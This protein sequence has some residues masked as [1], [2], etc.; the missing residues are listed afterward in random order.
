[1]TRLL[2][3]LILIH[4]VTYCTGLT[5]SVSDPVDLPVGISANHGDLCSIKH[6]VMPL[7]SR[8]IQIENLF[9]ANL[10]VKS[11]TSKT[12]TDH[13]RVNM[14]T[15]SWQQQQNKSSHPSASQNSK[16]GLTLW[17]GANERPHQGIHIQ[18]VLNNSMNMNE[19][20]MCWPLSNH[21]FIWHRVESLFSDKAVEN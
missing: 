21:V 1:M 4:G 11:L 14:Y 7:R 10:N 15:A 2:G 18:T 17:V 16:H 12:F 8:L 20:N 6:N 9:A 5:C 19:S 13:S 3:R